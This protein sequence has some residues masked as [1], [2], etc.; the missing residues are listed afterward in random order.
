MTSPFFNCNS[1]MQC[2]KL[3]YVKF[4]SGSHLH[5][6]SFAH[7]NHHLLNFQQKVVRVFKCKIQTR[8]F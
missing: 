4:I 6:C 8:F 1:T 2:L 7:R 3:S 5:S